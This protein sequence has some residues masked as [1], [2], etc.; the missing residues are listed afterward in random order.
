[1]GKKQIFSKS[2]LIGLKE[3]EANLN[4]FRSRVLKSE[5][6]L[7]KLIHLRNLPN[8]F[9]WKEGKNSPRT[10]LRSSFA[11]DPKLTLLESLQR[12]RR[13]EKEKLSY[14][15]I[16]FLLLPNGFESNKKKTLQ[17]F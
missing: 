14:V 6:M 9:I 3:I 17:K 11:E 13:D 10:P 7:D 8:F 2:Y 5:T 16:P 15:V 1:M 12:M 4:C